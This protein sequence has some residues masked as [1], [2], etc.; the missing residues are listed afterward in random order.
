[1]KR[2][3][4]PFSIGMIMGASMAGMYL[5]MPKMKKNKKGMMSPYLK[6]LTIEKD[7]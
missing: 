3:M 1:M 2:I 7:K 4:G 6:N 5:M